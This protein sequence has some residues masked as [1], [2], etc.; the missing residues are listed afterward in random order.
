MNKGG[1]SFKRLLGISRAK[2]KLARY[3]GVPTTKQGR[4]RK[5]NSIIGKLLGIK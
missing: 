1:F 4:K 5:I 2:N 3:T